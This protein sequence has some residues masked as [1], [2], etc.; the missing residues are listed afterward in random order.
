[1]PFMLTGSNHKLWLWHYFVYNAQQ[2]LQT[3]RPEIRWP[4]AT[5]ACLVG[6]LAAV[7]AVLQETL[8]SLSL[9]NACCAQMIIQGRLCL[10]VC[11]RREMNAVLSSVTCLFHKGLQ[12]QLRE[13]FSPLSESRER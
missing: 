5:A 11:T 12:L 1:M 7:C 10:P 9:S 13:L 3:S 6:G 2:H 4:R 8:H